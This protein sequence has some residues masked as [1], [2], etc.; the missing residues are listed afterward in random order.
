[1]CCRTA[2]FDNDKQCPDGTAC[3]WG[4]LYSSLGMSVAAAGEEVVMG[5]PGTY[6]WKG[7]VGAVK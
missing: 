2:K 7:T 4:S 3:P 6:T 5:A 1:M